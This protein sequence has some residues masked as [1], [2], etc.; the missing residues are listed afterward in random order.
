MHTSYG[1]YRWTHLPFGINSAPEEFQIRLMT[2]LEVL[3][4]IALVADDILVFGVGDTYAGAEADHDAKIL[5]LMAQS[6]GEKYQIQLWKIPIQKDSNKVCWTHHYIGWY[7]SRPRQGCCH[8]RH[9]STTRQG[10]PSS[11]HRYDKLSSPYC[12]NLSSTIR[13]LTELTKGGMAF[14]WSDTQNEAFIKAKNIIAKAPVL[15]YFS[16]DKPV[17]LQVDASENG[18]GGA[19]LQPNEDKDLQPVAYTSCSLAS[20]EKR[21]SQIEK[22][23]LAISNAFAKFDHWVY[24]HSSIEV[25]TDH[26]PLE[27]IFKKPLNKAPARLQRMLMRL[28]R[29]QFNVVYK[30]RTSLLYSR[31]SFESSIPDSV[32]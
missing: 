26:K 24:G 4:R 18:L 22:E 9:G 2:A 8:H 5:A 27:I 31:H 20:T 30:K 13:P 11:L 7:E 15:Q 12:E 3:E 6:S 25:H 23:C 10:R 32:N 21:Y 29:Y 17:T 19:L 16:L 28:Q 1:R 14:M